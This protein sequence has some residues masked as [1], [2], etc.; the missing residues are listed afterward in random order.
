M[1]LAEPPRIPSALPEG[2]CTESKATEPTTSRGTAASELS[3][4]YYFST[5]VLQYFSFSVLQCLA[6][7]GA[8]PTAPVGCPHSPITIHYFPL[9]PGFRY[10]PTS[11]ASFCLVR[12]GMFFGSVR[13]ACS[14]AD[15]HLQVRS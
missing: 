2:V 9:F 15:A 14:R 10:F 5:S 1:K 13:M 8:H 11:S 4:Q 12:A 3:A 6:P 7:R